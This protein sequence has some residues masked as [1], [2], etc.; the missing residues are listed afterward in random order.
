[1]TFFD[2]KIKSHLKLCKSR[3]QS[4]ILNSSWK[5]TN[6][7]K[8]LCLIKDPYELKGKKTVYEKWTKDTNHSKRTYIYL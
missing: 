4:R 3:V 2:T 7:E 5:M 6:W 1:M 8:H